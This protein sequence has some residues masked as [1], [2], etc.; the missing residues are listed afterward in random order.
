VDALL[1]HV[2]SVSQSG[3]H[4]WAAHES[5]AFGSGSFKLGQYLSGL[6]QWLNSLDLGFG[7][8]VGNES[9]LECGSR[10]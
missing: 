9:H 7:S 10:H 6:P 8:L 1:Y 4:C 5:E 2:W 3:V